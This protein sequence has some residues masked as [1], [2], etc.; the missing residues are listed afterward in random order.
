MFLLLPLANLVKPF[1]SRAGLEIFLTLNGFLLGSE[2]IEVNQ[3]NRSVFASPFR[4]PP[5]QVLID[6]R[7]QIL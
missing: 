3:G 4:A 5:F 6:A 7:K 2:F 1:P